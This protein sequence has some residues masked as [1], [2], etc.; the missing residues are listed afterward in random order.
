M[1][2]ISISKEQ[3][4]QQMFINCM[5]TITDTNKYDKSSKSPLIML[6]IFYYNIH[7]VGKTFN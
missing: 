6:F 3:K 5:Y 4:K 7:I 2:V 1:I